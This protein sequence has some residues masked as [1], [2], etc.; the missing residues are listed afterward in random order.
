MASRLSALFA[1]LPLVASLPAGDTSLSSGFSFAAANA[2]TVDMVSQ[3]W[4]AGWHAVDSVSPVFAVT[5]VSWDKYT[6][7]VYS[8]AITTADNAHFAL[9]DA[10]TQLLPDFVKAAHDNSVQ[11]RLAVGGWGGSQYFSTAFGSASNRTAAVKTLLGMISKYK[12][13]GID[14]DWEYPN[15]VGI[16]CNVK[17][18]QDSHNFLLALQELRQ[19]PAGKNLTLSAAVAK[20][21]D[22]ATPDDFKGFA[23]ALDYIEIMNY[24]IFGNWSTGMGPNAPLNDSCASAANQ[25]GSAVSLT[26]AWT[27]AGIPAYKIVLGVASYGHSF[28]I[29]ASSITSPSMLAQYPAFNAGQSQGAKFGDSWTNESSTD[30]CGAL[31]PAGGDIDF[32]GL[33]QEGFLTSNGS[34]PAE[35]IQHAFD[36]CA[37]TDY[38]FNAKTGVAVSYDSPRAFQVKGEFIKSSGLRGFSMWE[39]GGDSQDILLDSIRAATG[40]SDDDDDCPSD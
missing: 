25:Q 15:N 30:Q 9:A 38:V 2:T 31:I 20:P 5:N 23:D 12:L 35:G 36:D 26:K 13:D 28:A 37:Q 6:S 16:G 39:G 19:D 27:E 33:L 22:G 40:F 29:E 7:V 4:F 14:F 24:D 18:D 10:D 21:F 1:L 32:W 3:T 8:F 17:N 34:A 11:A